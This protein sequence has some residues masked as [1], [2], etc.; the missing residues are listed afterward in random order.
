MTEADLGEPTNTRPADGFKTSPN[1]MV[2]VD[3]IE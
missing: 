2:C 3:V 1:E